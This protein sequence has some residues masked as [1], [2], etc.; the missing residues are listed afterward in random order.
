MRHNKWLTQKNDNAEEYGYQ[1]PCT[2]PH[3]E[4]DGL[5]TAGE[6]RSIRLAATHTDGQDACAALDGVAA[7][8]DHHRKEVDLLGMPS[9]VAPQSHYPRCVIWN[10][11]KQIYL[12]MTIRDTLAYT[13]RK[14]SCFHWTCVFLLEITSEMLWVGCFLSLVLN[15]VDLTLPQPASQLWKCLNCLR[16]NMA[17]L[18][19]YPLQQNVLGNFCGFYVTFS[20]H[21]S[22]KLEG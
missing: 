22:R 10:R 6:E 21:K 16:D 3:W 14:W 9:E 11:K 7:V 5:C 2:Q 15:K 17:A 12:Q 13:M 1:G 19:P 18:H 4:E 8:L 20:R